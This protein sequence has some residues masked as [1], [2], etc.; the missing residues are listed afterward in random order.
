MEIFSLRFDRIGSLYPV[1]DKPGEVLV[2]SLISP[3]FYIDGRAEHPLDRGPFA[4]AKAYFSA[5]AQRELDCARFVFSQDTS[6]GY[7]RKVEEER[8]N[9]ERSMSLFQRLIDRCEGLDDLDPDLAPFS[10][11]IHS[12]SLKAITVSETDNSQ[13]VCPSSPRPFF[14][15]NTFRSLLTLAH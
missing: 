4:S 5:C 13:I 2:G 15:A 10:L 8:V 7:Q 1:L 12:L 14:A 9:V 3:P 11:D 6:A